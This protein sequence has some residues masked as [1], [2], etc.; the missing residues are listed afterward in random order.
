MRVFREKRS[1]QGVVREDS[2]TRKTESE[3]KGVSPQ[4]VR[5]V[6]GLLV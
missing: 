2:W 6:M 5:R 3:Y 4:E 1:P